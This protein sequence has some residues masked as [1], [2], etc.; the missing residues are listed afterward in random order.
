MT[1][2]FTVSILLALL[3]GSGVWGQGESPEDGK[4][5][6]EAKKKAEAKGSLAKVK[7]GKHWA[8][9]ELTAPEHLKGKVVLLQMWGGCV[10]CRAI[11]PGM[12]GLARKLDGERFHVVASYCQRGE[13]DP[14]LKYLKS[15]GWNDEMANLSVMF[16]TRYR[17]EDIKITYY[18]YYLIFD[19]T[20]KLRYHHM[21]GKYHGGDGDKYQELVAKLLKEIPR[22]EGAEDRAL[23]DLRF[24]TI[25]NG[26]TLR[27]ALLGVNDDL[28]KFRSPSGRSY[29]YPLKK[30]SNKSRK[31][32]E[33]LLD[34]FADSKS[35]GEKEKVAGKKGPAKEKKR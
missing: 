10:G 32:I 13:K 9:P 6:G 19:H 1:R 24:W 28:A 30:L 18:P 23:S 2:E 16:Q 33:T 35:T 12:V 22:E 3:L 31:D 15:Q 5:A 27:A 17:S 26:R 11:T 21:A 29:E 14:V 20:G 4:P 34:E 7:W 8:G 25:E